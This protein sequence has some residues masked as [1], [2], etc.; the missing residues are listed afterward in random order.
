MN[1]IEV[2]NLTKHYQ[3]KTFSREIIPAL[4]NLN[5]KIDSGKIFGLL[6]PNGAGKTT[7]V[8]ILLGIV[9][10][11]EGH[12]RIFGEDVRNYHLHSRIGFLPEDHKFPDYLNADE[13]MNWFGSMSGLT[14]SQIKERADKYLSMVDIIQWRKMKIKKYSKGM[15]QRLGLAQALINE[16][17]LIFLDEPT[18]GVDPIGRKKIRDILIDLKKEG[19]T[20][21]INSHLLSEVELVCDSVAI[22]NNGTLVKEGSVTDLTISSDT[23]KMETSG[24]DDET[25]NTLLSRFKAVIENRNSFTVKA[26]NPAELN[27]IIDF[28]RS[29]GILITE[30]GKLKSTLE[31]MFIEVINTN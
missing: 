20:I 21:L 28:L 17:E 19:K 29:R 16:P 14:R 10:P 13:L 4:R 31:E 24:L 5:L 11:T 3:S 25:V 22:L 6:G 18:D 27:G 15:L 1:I 7:L 30:I 2:E 26:D 9:F 23:Y 12:A 8:K